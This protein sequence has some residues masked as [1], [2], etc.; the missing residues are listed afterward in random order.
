MALK[1]Q[2]ALAFVAV[3]GLASLIPWKAS[4]APPSVTVAAACASQT[5]PVGTINGSLFVLQTGDLCANFTGS[6]TLSNYALET[7]QVINEGYLATIAAA[8]ANNVPAV[9]TGG[10]TGGATAYHVI[11]GASDNHVVIKNGAG[12]VYAITGTS[13]H[14]TYQ[15]VRLYDAGTGFSGCNSATNLKAGY[16]VPGATTGA[17]ATFTIPVGLA[18]PASAAFTVTSLGSFNAGGSAVATSGNITVTANCGVNSY[19]VGVGAVPASSNWH[20]SDSAGNTYPAAGSPNVNFVS[21]TTNH[22]VYMWGLVTS[23]LTSGVST[24]N[25]TWTTNARPGIVWVCVTG[26]ATSTPTD[27]TG[28]GY[29]SG[30]GTV[31]TLATHGVTITPVAANDIV[32]QA[33]GLYGGTYSAWTEDTNF[34]GSFA[35]TGSNTGVQLAYCI[36]ACAAAGTPVAY[37]PSW[38]TVRT[39][40]ASGVA[41]KAASAAAACRGALV[42]LGVGGC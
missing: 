8:T 33:V 41:L 18:A 24:V 38:T 40:G 4:A 15:Y 36:T 21:N 34:L 28:T 29:D 42:L 10:T 7:T 2:R 26:V 35:S 14:T 5:L 17:G 9:P 39:V 32:F 25:W 31:N 13:I 1:M 19:V 27:A 30:A 11:A 16:I 6:I 20:A 3:L 37:A 12:T 23:A 22:L